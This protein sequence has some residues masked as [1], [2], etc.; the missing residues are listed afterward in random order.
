MEALQKDLEAMRLSSEEKVVHFQMQLNQSKTREEAKSNELQTMKS[1]LEKLM[2]RVG[3]LSNVKEEKET[4]LEHNKEM[5]VALQSRIMEVEPE[6]VQLRDKVKDHERRYSALQLLKVEQD[7]VLGA[8]Q[9]ELKNAIAEKEALLQKVHD[10]EET[11]VKSESQ[12]VKL[13]TLGEEINNLKEEIEEKSAIIMRL[14]TEAQTSERNHAM[15]TAMLATCEA[16]V[17]TLQKELATKDETTKDA[18]ERVSSL[19][20]SLAAL[21]A[22]LDE[23]TQEAARQITSLEEE[24]E[25]QRRNYTQLL[26]A[27]EVE[28]QE[29]IEAAKRDYGKKSAMAR[30]LLSERE[31]EVRVLSTKVRELQEEIASGAPTERKI[32]ELA[33][34]Q[35]RRDALNGVHRYDVCLVGRY[36]LVVTPLLSFAAFS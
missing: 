34:V 2:S 18:L 4:L 17:E 16:Q 3:T 26:R 8:T 1:E 21:E 7:N 30:Q 19:Q 23:R 11:R 14:R 12:S 36:I 15:R 28:Q 13:T 6:V 5:I 9:R 32:F 22:R 35:S 27:K 25:S 10:L 24:Q 31:E 20:I 29:A 33:Q